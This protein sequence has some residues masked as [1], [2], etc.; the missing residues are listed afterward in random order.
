MQTLI[1][2]IWKRQL[3]GHI[4]LFQLFLRFWILKVYKTT[5]FYLKNYRWWISGSLG[6]HPFLNHEYYI[7]LLWLYIY[8]VNF[9][10]VLLNGQLSGIMYIYS[11]VQLSLLS[12]FRTFSSSWTEAPYTLNDN[13]LFRYAQCLATTILLSVNLPFLHTSRKWLAYFT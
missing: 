7:F 1:L 6:M 12:I 13:S 2:N 4:L 9:I 3:K 11:V 10:V 5:C 8:I